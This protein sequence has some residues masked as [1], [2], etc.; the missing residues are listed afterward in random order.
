MFASDSAFRS[1]ACEE[2]A[3][4]G[5]TLL[6]GGEAQGLI[7]LADHLAHV[8]DAARALSL[9]AACTEDFGRA[10]GASVDG[11]A[12]F[13]LADAVAIADVQGTPTSDLRLDM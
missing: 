8:A 7:L 4:R 3:V 9:R 6:F 2:F 11:G 1:Q 13:A 12:D 10:S 5:E